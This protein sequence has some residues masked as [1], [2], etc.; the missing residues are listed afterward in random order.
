MQG[1]VAARM[2]NASFQR[3]HRTGPKKSVFFKLLGR[4][5]FHLRSGREYETRLL[6]P[7]ITLMP[8][9]QTIPLHSK[10]KPARARLP[11][12]KSPEALYD[13]ALVA[14]FIDGDQGAFKEIVHLHCGR[15]VGVAQ[16]ALRDYA[17]A[18]DIAQETFIRAYRG[19]AKFR[20]EACLATWLCCIAL[21]LARNRYWYFFRRRRHD[22]LSLDQTMDEGAGFSLTDV[23]PDTAPNPRL[24][25]INAE[26]VELVEECMKL[27]D[28][29]H[30]EILIMRNVLHQSYGEIGAALGINVGTVKSR[31]ARARTNL[32]TLILEKAPEFGLKAA[33]EDFFEASRHLPSP[34]AIAS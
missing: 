2:H 6:G 27:L 13:A 22:T 14:R 23:L 4:F 10:Q 3:S 28:V 29:Y 7:T 5:R 15:I 19:L 33:M 16:K 32:R 1:L 18:Q 9:I 8:T 26:F 11:A 17:D 20:G 30:R 24:E 34:L 31:I 21:N 12:A 25:T